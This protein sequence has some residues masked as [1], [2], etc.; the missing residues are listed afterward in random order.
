MSEA[1]KREL[2]SDKLLHNLRMRGLL[3]YGVTI[4]TADMIKW[5]GFHTDCRE[6]RFE[7]LGPVKDV[8]LRDHLMWLRANGNSS[9]T[10][11]MPEDQADTATADYRKKLL[12]AGRDAHKRLKYIN[13]G[14]LTQEQQ[15]HADAVQERTAELRS[16]ITR[17]VKKLFG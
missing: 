16:I 12:K 6:F 14:V 1:P 10:I 4:Q 2:S 5:S 15:R 8:L 13:R 3:R 7:A 9:Y 11:I 17:G